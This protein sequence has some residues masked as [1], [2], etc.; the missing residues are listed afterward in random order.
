MALLAAHNEAELDATLAQ[1]ARNSFGAEAVLLLRA[2]RGEWRVA[3]VAAQTGGPDAFIPLDGPGHLRAVLSDPQRGLAAA[4]G[5]AVLGRMQAGDPA[6]YAAHGAEWEA[7]IPAHAGPDT[8]RWGGGAAFGLVAGGAPLGVLLLGCGT[9]VRHF[10]EDERGML[11]A[12]AAQVAA[13]L[14][15]W[16][17]RHRERTDQ[18]DFERLIQV[19]PVPVAV[20]DRRGALRLVNDAYLA[21]LGYSRAEFEAGEIDWLALTAPED[22]ESDAQAVLEAFEVGH[23]ETYHKQMRTRDGHPLPLSVSMVRRGEGEDAQMVGYLRDLRDQQA[24]DQL[25]LDRNTALEDLLTANSHELGVR[26][27]QVL[28]QH[29]E[30]GIRARALDAFALLTR[31]LALE[32]DRLALVR[33]AQEIV[34]DLLPPGYAVYFEPQGRS[35]RLRAQVGSLRNDELQTIADAGL[36]LETT[37]NLLDPWQ[38]GAPVYQDEYDATTDAL[39]GDLVSHVGATASLL[40]SVNGQPLGVF[41]VAVF[42]RRRWSA[43]DRSLLETVVN[44]LGLALE[45]A[46]VVSQLASRS[47]ELERSNEELERFAYA[48]SH[49]LLAPLRAMSGF[50]ELLE[51]RYGEVLEGRGQV[52]LKQ[53]LSN[54]GYMRQLVDDLLAYSRLHADHTPG[55]PCDTDQLVTALVARLRDNGQLDDAEVTWAGLPTVLGQPSPL[56]QLFENMVQNALKYRRPGVSPRVQLAAQR[57]GEQWRFT[58]TDNGIGIAPENQERVFVIFQRLHAREEFEGTGIGL[59]LCQKIVEQYGGQIGVESVPGEGSTFWFILPALPDA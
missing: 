35:W 15:Q 59:A 56:A 26:A 3:E 54:A 20:T 4:L 17:T 51:R 19:S 34:L 50:A 23:V 57:R 52:Y 36:P 24:S 7:L 38:T 28:S 48:A 45:R 53:I 40:V 30:L 21:L 12:V 31:D 18:I 43:T 10:S 13:R 6:V 32:T 9:G 5:Q 27:E 39:D 16:Q 44:N 22:R 58:V 1:L 46:E 37:R 33:R 41:A 29:A 49:D 2:P 8:L 42:G 47:R 14:E 25:L 55:Q 11:S